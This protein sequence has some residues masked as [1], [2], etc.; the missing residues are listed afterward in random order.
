M[1]PRSSRSERLTRQYM[2]LPPTSRTPERAPRGH[3]RHRGSASQV[4]TARRPR[5]LEAE[6][7]ARERSTEEG[8]VLCVREAIH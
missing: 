8:S 7:N 5:H 1:Q 4:A 3:P 2:L 6:S